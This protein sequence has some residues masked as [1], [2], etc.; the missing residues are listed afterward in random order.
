MAAAG[1]PKMGNVSPEGCGESAT[2]A[3]QAVATILAPT[4]AGGIRHSLERLRME[5]RRRRGTIAVLLAVLLTALVA[6]GAFSL[7]TNRLLSL[8]NELQ[9]SADAGAHAGALQ[10][11]EPNDPMSTADTATSYVRRYLAMQALVDVDS[12]ELGMWDDFHDR[13]V[14]GLTPPNAVR[15]V[16]S[17][18]PTGL[19]V[20]HF[21]LTTPR[22]RA[23]AVAWI[24]SDSLTTRT[25]VVLAQ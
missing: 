25:K 18:R 17:Q 5:M 9:F 16:V 2:L 3:P 24:L 20:S 12:V 21:G 10:L 8:R 7:D 15:V 22:V 13:F 6:V 1:E 14:P 19:L 11:V 4:A 23:R